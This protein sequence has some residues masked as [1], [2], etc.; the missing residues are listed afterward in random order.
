[1]TCLSSLGEAWKMH[2]I[3]LTVFNGKNDITLLVN[4]QLTRPRKLCC[5][6]IL[7]GVGVR[8]LSSESGTC[9]DVLMI[10]LTLTLHLPTTLTKIRTSP[11]LIRSLSTTRSYQKNAR[12][13]F[14]KTVGLDPN[15]YVP[16]DYHLILGWQLLQE[17]CNIPQ[18][19]VL[20]VNKLL[21]KRQ[22]RSPYLWCLDQTT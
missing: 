7:Q 13:A 16:L 22:G 6:R 21:V 10:A 12:R 17:A 11:T 3:M 15:R 9:T 14:L 18:L 5:R 8:F 4:I 20:F 1:M 19:F 2:K